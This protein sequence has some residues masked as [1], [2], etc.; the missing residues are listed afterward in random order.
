MPK[1]N[2]A[3]W[4]K[5]KGPRT[6]THMH[7]TSTGG[8]KGTQKAS[9]NDE[10][11][12]TNSETERQTTRGNKENNKPY[13]NFIGCMNKYAKELELKQSNFANPHG[14]PNYRNTSTP[15][16]QAILISSCLEIPF[17]CKVVN[18]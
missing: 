11:R 3:I 4:E 10:S 13:D 18:T 6:T 8:H 15:Y 16:D 17:F 5:K 9:T 12:T 1:R 2:K 14:L 7:Y